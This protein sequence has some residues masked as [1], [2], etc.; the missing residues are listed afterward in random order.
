MNIRVPVSFRIN[1]F[2]SF[3]KI[4]R[5]QIARWYG[6]S[7]FNFLR[8]F[9]TVSHSVCINSDSHQQCT[10]APF[11]LIFINTCYSFIF[12]FDNSHSDQSEVMLW[13]W[14]EFLDNW[15]S[16][17]FQQA[18]SRTRHFHRWIIPNIKELISILAKLFQEIE[19]EWSFPLFLVWGRFYTS[20]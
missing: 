17:L 20:I 18:K 11:L 8:N 16:E 14:F 7:I 15:L 4:H 9:H 2:V 13:F 5:N 10:R 1:V 6:S 19:K 3:G 12:L